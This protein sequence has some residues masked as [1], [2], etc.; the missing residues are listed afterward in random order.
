MALQDT[1]T[2]LDTDTDPHQEAA[3]TITTSSIKI[4]TDKELTC[5]TGHQDSSTV[6]HQREEDHTNK[7]VIL[8]IR[9][10][11]HHMNPGT[12]MSIEAATEEAH[13][14]R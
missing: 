9:E 6:L 8:E 7:Q 11:C 3:D 12:T 5:I 2:A 14:T 1:T 13:L 10:E 4:I